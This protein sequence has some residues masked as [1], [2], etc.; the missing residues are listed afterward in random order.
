[1]ELLKD[2]MPASAETWIVISVVLLNAYSFGAN[3]VERFVNNQSWP[4]LA[5]ADFGPYHRSQQPWI[6]GFVVAPLAVALV[7]QVALL[8]SRPQQIPLWILWTLVGSSVAGLITTFA[9]QI[10]IHRKLNHAYYQPL[11]NRLLRTDWIRKS[12]DAVRLTVTIVLLHR[13]LS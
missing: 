2:T 13:L 8:L 6:L 4:R 3:C 12:A 7:L 10:P 9:L 1:M 11:V 5:N